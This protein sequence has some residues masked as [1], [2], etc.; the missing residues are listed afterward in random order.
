MKTEKIRGLLGL[1]RR[2]RT[3]AIGSRETR[4]GL[5]RGEVRLVLFASDGSPRDRERL[6]RLLEEAAVPFRTVATR[7]QLGAWIGESPVAVVGLRDANLAAAVL[8]GL[9]AS[10]AENGGERT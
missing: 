4:I 9:D 7:E 2:A 5:R 10:P 3:V 1:A 8:A 6:L